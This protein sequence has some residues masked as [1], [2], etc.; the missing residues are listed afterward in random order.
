MKQCKNTKQGNYKKVIY[1]SDEKNDDFAGTKI[2]TK[3][4]PKN[5]KYISKNLFWNFFAFIAYRIIAFPVA[6]LYCKLVNK[7]KW[8]NKKVL[9][10]A[11]NSG[12]FI[13]GN[14]TS[15]GFDAFSPNIIG[16]PKKTHIVTSR[17][18]TSIFGIRQLV[19]M[20]GALPVPDGFDNSKKYYDAIQ[21]RIAQNRVV[22][23]YPEAHIW[24]YYTKIRNFSKSS[25]RHPV[26]LN[27]PVFCFTTT[28]QKHFNKKR[29]RV[30]VYIDGPYFPNVNI[31]KKEQIIDL[32]N[33]VYSTMCERSKNSNFEYIKYIK[34]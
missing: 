32:R 8:V 34:K 14:H 6:Y 31:S 5:F 19:L 18:A 15:L 27:K 12:Y 7:A 4:L 28:Y 9:K 2:T 29:P 20:L 30:V 22:C 21:K 10:Q 25:F 17:D 24:P 1:Y 23:I 11:K 3:K 16:F 26:E 33:R 13:Y